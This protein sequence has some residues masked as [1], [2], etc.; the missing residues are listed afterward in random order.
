MEFIE[1]MNYPNKA[2]LQKYAVDIYRK[3][4]WSTST[5]KNSPL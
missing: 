4:S 5:S 2:A 1:L 3:Y